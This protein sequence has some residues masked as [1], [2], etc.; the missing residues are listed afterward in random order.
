MSLFLITLLFLLKMTREINTHIPWSS[1]WDA[2]YDGG[3]DRI[4]EWCEEG[5]LRAGI[6]GHL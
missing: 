2:G 1:C 6:I 3:Y 5:E 4:D